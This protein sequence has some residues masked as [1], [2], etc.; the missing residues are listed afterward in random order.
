M[1]R[2]RKKT[3]RNR[4]T[5]TKCMSLVSAASMWGRRRNAAA[6]LC[7][8]AV[9]CFRPRPSSSSFVDFLHT[10]RLVVVG[11]SFFY[12]VSHRSSVTGLDCNGSSKRITFWG[13]RHNW[14]EIERFNES[15]WVSIV[16]KHDWNCECWHSIRLGLI[17]V[18]FGGGI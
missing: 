2:S 3:K 13:L 4:V 12:R 5:A 6:F 9:I 18:S 8:S 10:D 1:S 16:S 17:G 7:A 15:Y 11:F 14:I